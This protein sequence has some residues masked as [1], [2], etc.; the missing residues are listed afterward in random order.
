MSCFLCIVVNCGSP[1]IISNGSLGILTGTT[2]LETASYTCA[3]GYALKSRRPFVTCLASGSWSTLPTCSCEYLG[4]QIQNLYIQYACRVYMHVTKLMY[5][6]PFIVI[7]F[8][9]IYLIDHDLE[10]T[11]ENNNI[12]VSQYY[13]IGGN[14]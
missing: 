12:I 4:L 3:F 5:P 14:E 1:P 10:D 11:K 8:R 7:M 2:F 13:N 9:S 6:K